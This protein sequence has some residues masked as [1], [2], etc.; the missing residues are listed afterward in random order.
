MSKEAQAGL[1]LK[2]YDLRREETMRKA[3]DWFFMEFHPATLD[4]FQAAMYGPHSGH[5][6][7]V[8]SYWDM[9]AALVLHET[10]DAGLFRDCNGEYIGVFSKIE[11]ILKDIQKAYSPRFAA[12]LERLIDLTPDGRQQSATQRERMKAI[13][14]KMPKAK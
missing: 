1:I 3:R 12:N 13:R 4:D 7:M 8:I 5:L 9:Y 10:I 6:R 11:P 2:L 14:E